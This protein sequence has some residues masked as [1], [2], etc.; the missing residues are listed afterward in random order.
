VA[1]AWRRATAALCVGLIAVAAVL[2]WNQ[3]DNV[4]RFYG[5]TDAASLRGLDV[6][7][8]RLRPHDVVVTDRCWSFLATWL[9]H[10]RTLP[11]LAPEDIGPAA[12]V[13]FARE[14][15]AVLAGQP[16]G[17]QRAHRLGAR[18]IV[19]DP[20][21]VDADSRPLPPPVVGEPIYVSRRLAVLRLGA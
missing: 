1:L 12:E 17:L 11:A 3:A 21:C 6:L 14:A 20:T 18:Y 5:F 16:A 19:V 15:R 13:P 10:T 9:V 7:S 2:A 4:R 8:A